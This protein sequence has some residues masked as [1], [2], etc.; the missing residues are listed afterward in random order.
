MELSL[1]DLGFPLVASLASLLALSFLLD[2]G[3][4]EIPLLAI[5]LIAIIIISLK[6]EASRDVKRA[7][8]LLSPLPL[9][10]LA[11]SISLPPP[12]SSISCMLFLL[13]LFLPLSPLISPDPWEAVAFSASI[14]GLFL[15]LL[16]ILNAFDRIP[17]LEI[18][19]AVSLISSFSSAYFNLR[20][21][22]LWRT[23]L[24]LDSYLALI[25]LIS[26][27][28]LLELFLAYPNIFRF[29]TNDLLYHQDE[30]WK[31]VMRPEDYGDWKYLGFHSL[32]SV[33]Y[34][35]TNADSFSVMLAV[36]PLNLISFLIVASSFSKLKWRSE[37]LFIWSL[38]TSLGFLAAIRYGTD[39]SGLD[40]ANEASYRSLI[41][42][43][44]ILF[45]GLPLTLAI[46]LLA[47]LIYTDI[48]VEGKRKI[49]YT[50]LLTSFSFFVHIAEALVFAAYLALASL[51][52]GGR[53]S[54]GIGVTLAGLLLYSLYLAPGVYEGSALSSSLYLLSA[55]LIALLFNESRER[56]LVASAS[57]L[58]G[59]LSSKRDI[60]IS[61][62]LALYSSGVII[63][64]LH[65]GEV[66]VSE[67]YYIGQVPWFFYPNLLGIS[68]LLALLSLKEKLEEP[69]A[70]Y[71]L[72]SLTALLLGRIVTQLK[73]AG[74]SVLYWE[75]RFPLYAAIGTAVLSA[76][77]LR[78]VIE[79]SRSSKMR[80]LLLSVMIFTGFSSTALSVQ[81]WNQINSTASG[82]ILPPDFDFAVKSSYSNSSHPF[83]LLTYYSSSVASLMHLRNTMR[84]LSPW[85]SEGPE[86]PLLVLSSVA[87]SDE[88]AVLTTMGDVA[89]LNNDNATYNYL[90]MFMGPVLQAP[91]VSL[92]EL[93][94][95][96]RPNASLAV[97]LPSDTYFMRRSLI[98]YELIRRELPAHTIYSSDDPKA[99]AGVY[100]GPSSANQSIREEIPRE[101]GDLRW[102]Y[103]RG[104]FSEAESGL[105]VRGPRNL[106]VTTYELDKGEFKLNACG[107]LT[108]YIG[109][110]YDFES[111]RNYRIFQVFLDRGIA[112]NRV[113]RE[114]N[115]T[116]SPSIAVPL[117]WE[118]NEIGIKLNDGLEADVNGR[119][120][121]LPDV[122][123]LGVLGFETGNF[124]GVVNG[125]VSG[126]HSFAWNPKPGSLLVSVSGGGDVDI[127]SWVEKGLRNLSETKRQFPGLKLNLSSTEKE[128][129][130]I[131]AVITGL[132]VNGKVEVRG[133]PIW[134]MSGE[135]RTYLN[136][137][138]MEIRAR[139]LEY[140][141]GDGFYAEL[142]LEGVENM[143]FSNAVIKFR[144]PVMI[145]AEGDVKLE[146][147]HQFRRSAP[148][149]RDVTTSRVNLTVLVADRALLLS[150]L[151]IP[152]EDVSERK[153]IYKTFDETEYLPETLASFIPLTLAFYYFMRRSGR[154]V[155]SREKTEK[156]RKRAL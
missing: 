54:S 131:E 155:A 17:L 18:L 129:P 62:L 58:F 61:L 134:V 94:E 36:I 128:F 108:G 41:W 75:Y 113:I 45:W 126:T 84:Q 14:S 135:G 77:L 65:L 91:S 88:V 27:F 33:I 66:R 64:Q 121:K 72:L 68:G 42:S 44:P 52:F 115:V 127:S 1:R 74:F 5:P 99:P 93:S 51:L 55:G 48:Y 37:A 34:A 73:L 153:L 29:T 30:A 142:K 6:F 60:V 97:V 124:T 107:D 119:S 95:P 117:S 154:I 46:A 69:L 76:P 98:A 116:S 8:L 144:T 16:M 109:I 25:I 132:R 47:F 10:L 152:K 83:L 90:F 133:R 15:S 87:G 92:L 57:R 28:F 22:S 20:G 78:K 148:E 81:R 104:D 80:A 156:K 101:R 150:E 23:R 79:G 82:S 137:S 120:F 141:R 89:F 56:Y 147:Y 96:P 139:K 112:V 114:G 151:E 146:R 111:F 40:K 12:F 122:K 7:E 53:R 145:R 71:A 59:F 24:L 110:I 86:V 50:F 140:L 143:N 105:R 39:Y 138:E 149:A 102:L 35:I 43:Q 38:F 123:K 49:L 125:T 21:K 118:C 67:I 13:L 3:V 4:F 85:I 26:L 70:S 136:V 32:L 100:I 103:L 31:L 19:V 106:A 11:L 130:E 63:W 2:L 9:I